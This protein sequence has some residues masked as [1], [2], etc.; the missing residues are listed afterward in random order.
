MCPND[1]CQVC[2][3]SADYIVE[4]IKCLPNCSDGFYDYL[5]ANNTKHC[6]RNF[7]DFA[8]STLF[9]N[10]SDLVSCYCPHSATTFTSKPHSKFLVM[11][12]IPPLLRVQRSLL[13][14]PDGIRFLHHLQISWKNGAQLSLLPEWLLSGRRELDLQR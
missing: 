3:N 9:F 6:A 10:F 2:N 4:H 5:G 7:S 14:L 11:Y 8:V 1:V 12:G 13:K